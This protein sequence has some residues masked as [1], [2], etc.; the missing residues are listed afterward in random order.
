M[1]NKLKFL[2]SLLL[3]GVFITS[4]DK[5]GD[6][7]LKP[8]ENIIVGKTDYSGCH[9]EDYEPDLV[10]TVNLDLSDTINCQSVNSFEYMGTGGLALYKYNDYKNKKIIKYLTVSLV[11][12]E[13]VARINDN[14]T[15]TRI[16]DS[17]D[18]LG[19]SSN[20][21]DKSFCCYTDFAAMDY[22][23]KADF[24]NYSY[25]ASLTDKYAGFRSTYNHGYTV[26]TWIHFSL[27]NLDTLI[28]HDAFS[29]Y[30][31]EFDE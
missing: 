26:Y 6:D 23:Y 11:G 14:D 18:T 22:D 31:V 2:F 5:K 4:C 25:N 30:F 8:L 3:V 24:I 7:K 29:T 9:Y 17:G 16:F 27:M 13:A 19:I 15:I 21:V 28:I 20:W 1:K 12:N 10:V